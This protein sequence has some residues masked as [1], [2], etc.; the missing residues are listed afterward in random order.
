VKIPKSAPIT[1]QSEV[2]PDVLRPGLTIVFCGTAPGAVSAARGFYYAHPYNKFWPTLHEVG[3]TP[4]RLAPEEYS[5]LPTWRIGLTDLAKRVFGMDK[6]LPPGAL[7]AEA[8]ADLRARI[9]ACQ[10]RILAFTS[11]T[12][13]RKFLRRPA[14]FG[15]QP[16]AIGRS[17]I[18]LLPSPSP[19]AQWNWDIGWW[20]KLAER[21]SELP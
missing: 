18:W 1:S 9:E 2:L 21:A 17:R 10:P 12:A 13:G 16:E 14:G 19:A 3:L 4:R 20:R 5:L 7:G 11:L 15:E 6:Q 8:A